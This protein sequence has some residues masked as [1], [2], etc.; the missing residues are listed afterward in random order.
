MRRIA[1]AWVIANEFLRQLELKYEQGRNGSRGHRPSE[2]EVL[3]AYESI[4]RLYGNGDK[5]IDIVLSYCIE[6]DRKPENVFEI[7]NKYCGRSGI[8]IRLQLGAAAVQEYSMNTEEKIRYLHG[9]SVINRLSVLCEFSNRIVLD[10]SYC[11]SA[12]TAEAII[13]F[14]LKFLVLWK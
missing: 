1:A 13:Y 2:A 11:F 14:G 6:I 12:E 9:K 8:M 5:W 4:S 3:C 7:Q 10:D